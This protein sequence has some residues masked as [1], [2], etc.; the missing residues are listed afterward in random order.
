MHSTVTYIV[1]PRNYLSLRFFHLHLT[2][3]AGHKQEN[4]TFLG[5]LSPVL[6]IGA[7]RRWIF[8]SKGF[9]SWNI[10]SLLNKYTALL[11]LGQYRPS[12]TYS[13]SSYAI[14]DTQF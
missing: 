11:E 13:F 2:Y 10:I 5:T 4:S 3:I 1:N 12:Q 14:S 7:L 6:N 9:I 8:V